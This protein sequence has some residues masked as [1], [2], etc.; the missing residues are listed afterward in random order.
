MGNSVQL[1]K[2]WFKVEGISSSG[3][4]NLTLRLKSEAVTVDVLL[5]NLQLK[6]HFPLGVSAKTQVN[7]WGCLEVERFVLGNINAVTAQCIDTEMCMGVIT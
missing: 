1:V 5:S 3:Y 6:K 7:L 4:N 2:G